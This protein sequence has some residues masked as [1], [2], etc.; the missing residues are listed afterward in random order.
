M[1]EQ[2]RQAVDAHGFV[3]VREPE[4]EASSTAGLTASGLPELVVLGLPAEVAHALLDELA[5]RLLA[6][7]DPDD[8]APL[9]DLLEGPAPV[10]LTVTTPVDGSPAAGLYGEL[11]RMRQLV[12]PDP[13]GRLPWHEGADTAAQPLLGTPPEWPLEED[14]HLQ[15]L[16]SRPVAL[17]GQPVLLVQRTDDGELRFLDGT[18]DFDPDRAAVECLHDALERDLSLLAAVRL[19]AE[20][21]T[22][23]RDDLG[24]PWTLSD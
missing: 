8:G 24:A 11:V 22:A 19:V 1:T 16:T 12:W 7:E 6:G 21:E 5:R 18:S 23:E 14:P 4:A 9:P 2:L 13:E 17:D 15:V 10:L 20:G 3:V